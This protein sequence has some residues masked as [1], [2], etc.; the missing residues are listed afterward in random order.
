LPRS[1]PNL[2]RITRNY[3][4]SIENSQPDV[5]ENEDV[6]KALQLAGKLL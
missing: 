2:I 6:K 1:V 5:R 4:P 3:P